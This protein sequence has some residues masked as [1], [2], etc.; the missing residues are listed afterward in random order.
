[1]LIEDL[2]DVV[3][4]RRNVTYYKNLGYDVP[5]IRGN[6][7]TIKSGSDGI[8]AVKSKDVNPKSKITLLNFECDCCGVHFQRTAEH[9][10]QR[11]AKTGDYHT[12]CEECYHIGAKDTMLK[13]YGYE[14]GGC[15][16]EAKEKQKQTC[17]EKYGVE[18]SFQSDV[19]RNKAKETFLKKYG[20]EHYSQTPEARQR[21]KEN[22]NQNGI[23]CSSKAQEKISDIVGGKLNYLFCG[24]YLDMLY[25]DWLDIEYDGSGHDLRVK[26]GKMSQEEFGKKERQRYAVIHANGLKTLTIKGNIKDILPDNDKL[27]R[28]IFSAINELRLTDKN[29][30][31]IDYTNLC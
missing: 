27:K 17:L 31:I 26:I 10:Y 13:R 25:E 21:A 16:P 14:Y 3:I 8:I 24:F 4:T 30:V 15:I 11:V 18:Y 22:F 6:S 29:S 1:M 2:V 12:Y 23:I 7:R 28:D 20:V 19:V 5:K 9:Y